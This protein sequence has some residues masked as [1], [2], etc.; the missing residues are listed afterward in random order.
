MKTNRFCIVLGLILNCQ[1][2]W[3]FQD[4]YEPDDS[5][6]EGATIIRVNNDAQQ[7]TLHTQ[8]DKDW[9]KFYAAEG[10]NYEVIA[11][12]VGTD[13]DIILELY[14]SDAP[15]EGI[16]DG[17]DAPLERIKDEGKGKPEILSWLMQSEGWYFI[18][19]SDFNKESVNCRLNIQ[20]ELRVKKGD[21]PTIDSSLQINVI[22]GTSGQPIEDKNARF[23]TNCNKND[24]APSGFE[25]GICQGLNEV[26]VEADG[27]QALSCQ[28]QIPHTFK[29]PF[30]RTISLWPNNQI[31]VLSPAEVKFRNGD[32]LRASQEI[33]RNGDNLKVEFNLHELPAYICARYYVG[34][35]Y[36]DGNLF[37]IKETINDLND[38]EALNEDGLKKLEPLNPVYL[39]HWIGEKNVVIEQ[40]VNDSLLRGNYLLY[41]LR[42]PRII[43]DP[44]NNLDKGELNVSQFRI[45]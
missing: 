9:F 45:K 44:V 25:L 22:D 19:V 31:P 36:P 26:F 5:T 13:I 23:Y 4:I 41:L 3:A 10:I 42:M 24:R 30:Q 21:G 12:Q 28:M 17:S 27:Y 18:K 38:K 1:V 34:I 15:L 2:T 20:Y 7:H 8:T 6:A 29:T 33:Y 11:D 37:I 40:S 14:G 32:T 35:A 39:P 43:N 16:N